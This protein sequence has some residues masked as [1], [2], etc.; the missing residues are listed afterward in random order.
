MLRLL[1]KTQ[2]LTY[3]A[4]ST[5]FQ[6]ELHKPNYG[7]A[8]TVTLIPGI[9]IGPEITRIFYFN[10]ESVIDVFEAA[11]VPVNFDVIND[12]TFENIQKRDLLKRNKCIL[13]GVMVP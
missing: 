12:F 2:R 5:W 8:Q 3:S 1:T 13:L 7:A 11:N 4:T 9:G 6:A 10:L